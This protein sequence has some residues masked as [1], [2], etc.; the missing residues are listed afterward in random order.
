MLQIHIV[1]QYRPKQNTRKCI[2]RINARYNEMYNLDLSVG[3]D[4]TLIMH[5]A[6]ALIIRAIDS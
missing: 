1:S 3:A 5:G 4:I 2:K 6:H